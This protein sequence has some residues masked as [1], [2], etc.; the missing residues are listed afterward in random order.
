MYNEITDN[1]NRGVSASV[2]Y[3]I[4]GDSAKS[5]GGYNS[6]FDNGNYD[7][8]CASSTQYQYLKAQYNWWDSSAG[9]DTTKL[10]G[11]ILYAPWLTSAP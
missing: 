5:I 6:I 1:D 9:P 10:Y 4:L 8:Y 2:H 3:P 7:V 11:H